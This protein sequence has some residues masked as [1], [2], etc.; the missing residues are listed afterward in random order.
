MLQRRVLNFFIRINICIFVL[1]FMLQFQMMWCNI[2]S[3]VPL[4][5]CLYPAV[6]CKAQ[7]KLTFNHSHA[8]LTEISISALQLFLI[9]FL[10][11]NNNRISSRQ[12]Y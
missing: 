5:H 2:V 12:Q 1:Y 10:H 7:D 3:L 6:P 11:M 9:S 4:F 8:M